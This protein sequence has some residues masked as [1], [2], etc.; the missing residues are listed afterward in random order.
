MRCQQIITGGCQ[1]KVFDELYRL[2]YLN[3]SL[4]LQAVEL[5]YFPYH[6]PG[7]IISLSGTTC[8][9]KKT[10]ARNFQLERP[11]TEIVDIKNP[12]SEFDLR[13]SDIILKDLMKEAVDAAFSTRDVLLCNLTPEVF[14]EYLKEIGVSLPIFSVLVFCPFFELEER[15]EI[16]NQEDPFDIGGFRDLFDAY[17]DYS[18]LYVTNSCSNSFVECL[19]VKEL[20]EI[21]YLQSLEYLKKEAEYKAIWPFCRSSESQNRQKSIILSTQKSLQEDFEGHLGIDQH[22]GSAKIS[23]KGK[24]DLVLMNGDIECSYDSDGEVILPKLSQELVRGFLSFL[25]EHVNVIET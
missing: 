8:S 19:S 18:K 2:Y 9:G 22:Y 13:K 4:K 21:Y 24:Y 15:V 5:Y 25:G 20:Q 14:L 6:R 3:N 10:L 11:K 12:G 16:K 17:N 1:N 7:I 23:S